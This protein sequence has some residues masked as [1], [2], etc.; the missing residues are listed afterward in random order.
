MSALRKHLA[1]IADR[2]DGDLERACVHCGACCKARVVIG[3]VPVQVPA[4]WCKHLRVDGDGKSQCA[5][6]GRRH[7]LAPWCERLEA[8][9]A[10]GLYP[11]DCPYVA[12][13]EPYRGTV[14]LDE[15]SYRLAEEALHRFLRTKPCPEWADPVAWAAYVGTRVAE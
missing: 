11:P 4:L 14:M 5:I 12:G 9:I 10:K 1:V 8:A 7:E 13:L 6:Y 15:P 2:H 3:G